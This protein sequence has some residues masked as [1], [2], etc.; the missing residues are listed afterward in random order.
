MIECAKHIFRAQLYSVILDH[1]RNF[2]AS[3]GV[4]GVVSDI[5][6]LGLFFFESLDVVEQ[7]LKS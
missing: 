2:H 5:W 6:V 4:L 3:A 1:R 7:N